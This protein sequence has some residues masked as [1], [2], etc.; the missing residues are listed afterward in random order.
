MKEDSRENQ[1]N[2]NISSFTYEEKKLLKKYM[3]EYNDMY[4]K[5]LILSPNEFI[6]K[7]IKH[8]EI[9]L[10]SKTNKYSKQHYWCEV[11]LNGRWYLCEAGNNKKNPGWRYFVS[12]YRDSSGYGK[13][14]KAAKD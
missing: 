8:V 13:F 11:K 9:S 7:L 4:Q 3:E 12:F 6:S 10:S 5:I 1:N 2:D 14:G